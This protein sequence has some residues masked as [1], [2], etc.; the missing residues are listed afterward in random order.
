VG[1]RIP[2]GQGTVKELTAAWQRALRR[3]DRRVLKRVTAL[4][5]LAERHSGAAA[6]RVGA[7]ASTAHGWLHAFPAGRCASLAIG[8]RPAAPPD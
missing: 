1:V 7:G 5:L 6:M 3:G 2:F 8:R 4:P